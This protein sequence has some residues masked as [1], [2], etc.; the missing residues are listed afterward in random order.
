ML[1]TTVKNCT[2]NVE[3]RG[4]PVIDDDLQAAF[5][6]SVES[7]IAF[8]QIWLFW[9]SPVDS[10]S[11]LYSNGLETWRCLRQK[12]ALPD[13]TMSHPWHNCWISNSIQPRCNTW[14]NM[15]P[16]QCER[17]V[18]SPLPRWCFSSRANL[19]NKATGAFQQ[20]LGLNARTL[21]YHCWV[22]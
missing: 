10:S 4:H 18:A 9:F 1:H 5:W 19:L 8:W 6:L 17:Q 15:E 11:D 13:A 3:G 12:F 14:Q 16:L 7:Y 2:G 22:L 20:E 21:R